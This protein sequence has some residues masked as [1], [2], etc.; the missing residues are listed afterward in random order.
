MV[1]FMF[2]SPGSILVVKSTVS[3][4]E[5]EGHETCPTVVEKSTKHAL[6]KTWAQDAT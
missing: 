3:G 1:V 2:R 5:H 4:F 6:Q